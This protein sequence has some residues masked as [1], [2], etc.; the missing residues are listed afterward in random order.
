MLHRLMMSGRGFPMAFLRAPV[1]VKAKH[2]LSKRPR[3]PQFISQRRSLSLYLPDNR[4][5]PERAEGMAVWCEKMPSM[6]M[7]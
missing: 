6:T 3:S 5:K 4:F 1:M 2:T 7:V